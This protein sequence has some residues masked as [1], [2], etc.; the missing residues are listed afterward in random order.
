M[1]R[2]EEIDVTKMRSQVPY[3]DRKRVLWSYDPTL[4]LYVSLRDQYR[5][6]LAKTYESIFR[7]IFKE[8][9]DRKI[10]RLGHLIDDCTEKIEDRIT[11]IEIYNPVI[12][13]RSDGMKSI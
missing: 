12:I 2:M 6:E 1:P 11:E 4:S 7:N 13:L 8:R 3:E 5:D 10:R 9:Y